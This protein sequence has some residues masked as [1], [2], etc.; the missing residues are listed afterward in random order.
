MTLLLFRVVFLFALH[1]TDSVLI[2]ADHP[3]TV[4]IK[5]HYG[6]LGDVVDEA[7]MVSMNTNDDVESLDFRQVPSPGHR[8]V[9]L[10]LMLFYALYEAWR[11][12]YDSVVAF[13]LRPYGIYALI[14]G[15]L[16]R[17][18]THLGIIG[19]DIDIHPKAWYGSIWPT[20]FRRFD[21]VSVLGTSHRE[22]LV[23]NGIAPERVYI[24]TNAVDGDVFSPPAEDD[25]TYDFLWLGRFEPWKRP[26]LFAQALSIL[27]ERNVEFRAVMVGDGPLHDEVTEQIRSS[28]LE[29]RITMPG[30]TEEPEMYFRDARIFALTSSRESL[31]LV[32]AEAMCTGRPC[33]APD[34]GNVSDIVRDGENG[35][36]IRNLTT[37]QLADALQELHE[38]SNRWAE[39]AENALEIRPEVSYDAARDD[40]RKIMSFHAK[41]N[42]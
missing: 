20:C 28:G 34:V 3:N 14:I 10:L 40:W 7:T 1:V 4:K 37:E 2:V 16:F 18:P 30:W 5:R 15:T 9:G 27:D 23:S 6:P 12:D 17:V 41:E 38:D 35:I 42:R 8:V 33:I 29:D 19:G 39:M 32:V 11:N 21:T 24:L 26:D 31:G 36:L 13:T 22:Y 25:P